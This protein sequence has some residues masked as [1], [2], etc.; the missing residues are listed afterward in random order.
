MGTKTTAVKDQKVTFVYTFDTNT[1][2]YYS[3]DDTIVVSRVRE[4]LP[5]GIIYISAMTELE[6]FSFSRISDDEERRIKEF[7][8]GVAIVPLDSNLA[9]FAGELRRTYRLKL[10]DSAIAATALR[11]N[12]TL[13]TRNVRDFKRVPSLMVEKI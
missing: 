5:L 11:M 7:L 4:L 9:R 8:D 2:I 6:L 1:I 13:V 12:S 10:A 3:N